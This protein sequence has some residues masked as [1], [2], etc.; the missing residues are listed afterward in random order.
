M[1][2]VLPLLLGL[3]IGWF[4]SLVMGTGTQVGI[5]LDL[6]VGAAGAILLAQLLGE[7]S[8]FDNLV[9]AAL[10]ALV[11]LGI[12]SLIRRLMPNRRSEME[13]S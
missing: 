3:L 12:M 7:G 6:V 11:A 2:I 13:S 4:A 9:S 10:G 8:T 5:L 1:D